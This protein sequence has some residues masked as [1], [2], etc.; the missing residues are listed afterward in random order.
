M[1]H[2]VTFFVFNNHVTYSFEGQYWVLFEVQMA[3]REYEIT[4]T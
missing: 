2:T 1:D 3:D 4:K